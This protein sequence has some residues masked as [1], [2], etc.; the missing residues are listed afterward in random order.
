MKI[1]N[2][3]SVVTVAG[4]VKSIG[5][6]QAIKQC[7]DSVT[8]SYDSITIKMLDSISM[9]SSVIGYLT[10]LVYKDNIHIKMIA[11]DHRLYE[12]LDELSLISQFNVQ[13]SY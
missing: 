6:L 3:D 8:Q 5:D 12:L 9:T 4:N 11:G 7:L 10:K 2:I 13:K 1:T